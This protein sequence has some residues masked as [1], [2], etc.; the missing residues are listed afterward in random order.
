[1]IPKQYDLFLDNPVIPTEELNTPIPEE[2]LSP[3]ELP[4]DD[5][6]APSPIAQQKQHHTQSHIQ[7]ILNKTQ[8]KSIH[9][10][11]LPFIFSLQKTW[12]KSIELKIKS[13]NMRYFSVFKVII[14]PPMLRKSI[15]ASNDEH[16]VLSGGKITSIQKIDRYNGWPRFIA[17]KENNTI[18]SFNYFIDFFGHTTPHKILVQ[19]IHN[20]LKTLLL[21]NEG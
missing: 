8:Q 18:H 6:Y 11:N 21:Q 2:N 1:M 12:E 9:I 15:D 10:G 17:S 20:F 7:S 13:E 5:Q 19:E 14:E 16:Y 3:S 4:P